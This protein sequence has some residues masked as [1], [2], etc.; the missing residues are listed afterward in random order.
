MI[1]VKLRDLELARR[2]PAAYVR[3]LEAP[4]PKFGPKSKHALL[5]LAIYRFHKYAGG[6]FDRFSGDLTGAIDYFNKLYEKKR[7]KKNPVSQQ[8]YQGQLITYASEFSKLGVDV[9]K[10]KDMLYLPLLDE[11]KEKATVCGQIP[12]VDLSAEGYNVWLFDK[13]SKNWRE[14]IRFPLIQAAYAKKLSADLEEVK[15]GVYD[16]STASYTSYSFNE[17]EVR[18]AETLLYSLLRQLIAIKSRGKK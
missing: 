4:K 9:I 8:F 2:D 10:T 14:E 16:F 12:R 13:T 3:K 6:L 11:F 5:L 7:F 15:V 17:D 1:R 18:E